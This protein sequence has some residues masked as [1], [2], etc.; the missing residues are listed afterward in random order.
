MQDNRI[1]LLNVIEQSALS[2]IDPKYAGDMNLGHWY[3]GI[4]A[5]LRR[6]RLPR[7]AW[8]YMNDATKELLGMLNKAR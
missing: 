6:V 3:D 7:E 2:V 8:D 4:P 1:R 5:D